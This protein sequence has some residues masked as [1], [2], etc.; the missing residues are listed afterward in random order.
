M[1]S[2][3]PLTLKL[4]FCWTLSRYSAT[5]SKSSKSPFQSGRS[6]SKLL[7]A[8]SNLPTFF[9]V[10]KCFCFTDDTCSCPTVLSK[11]LSFPSILD[12]LTSNALK[13][14]FNSF[15]FDPIF[16]SLSFK[17]PFRSAIETSSIAVWCSLKS[18]WLSNKTL[19]NVF[20]A[21]SFFLGLGILC[22]AHTPKAKNNQKERR[23]GELQDLSRALLEGNG[24]R[25]DL[26]CLAL[27]VMPAVHANGMASVLPPPPPPL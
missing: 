2:F 13:S 3:N 11:R 25:N 22:N 7:T 6:S 10:D 15:K 16:C 21:R 12:N 8:P 18:G 20:S 27:S 17:N 24:R 19:H 23:G 1:P 5:K 9:Y 4:F 26:L 14:P